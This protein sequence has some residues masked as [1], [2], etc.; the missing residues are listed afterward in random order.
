MVALPLS[1]VGGILFVAAL[2]IRGAGVL[3]VPGLLLLFGPL[4]LVLDQGWVEVRL[5]P[6]GF[7][8]RRAGSSLTCTWDEVD[9]FYLRT[10]P[11]LVRG[12]GKVV[13]VSFRDARPT[14]PVNRRALANYIS[15]VGMDPD[16]ELELLE[17]WRRRW[18]RS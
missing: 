11:D 16:A 17:S 10:V 1:V 13:T 8:I 7:T 5:T 18:S 4:L 14:F 9:H 3:V 12:S 2:A 15:S 6:E